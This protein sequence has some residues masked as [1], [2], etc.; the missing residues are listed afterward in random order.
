MKKIICSQKLC[1]F[2]SRS[3]ASRLFS[4]KSWTKN[5]YTHLQLYIL[6][7]DLTIP[8]PSKIYWCI[9]VIGKCLSLSPHAKWRDLT[10]IG[11][12]MCVCYLLDLLG[13]V[14]FFGYLP[15]FRI[16]FADE[17]KPGIFVCHLF[18]PLLAGNVHSTI[19]G[20][21]HFS[22][23]ISFRFSGLMLL[24]NHNCIT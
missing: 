11:S 18:F 2:F 19:D 8:R 21:K 13:A 7:I 5:K 16:Y 9:E 23:D 20:Q 24:R 6:L 15:Q 4:I 17:R 12:D 22:M 1:I 10:T 3:S 14:I